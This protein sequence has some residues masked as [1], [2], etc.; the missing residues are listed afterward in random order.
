MKKINKLLFFIMI[1]LSCILLSGCS[2]DRQPIEWD[3]FKF[4]SFQAEYLSL[5]Q[6][7]SLMV[8]CYAYGGVGSYHSGD[9]FLIKRDFESLKEKTNGR[10][11]FETDRY[12]V[13]ERCGEYYNIEKWSVW[14][15]GY[16]CCRLQCDWSYYVIIDETKTDYEHYK[17]YGSIPFPAC[18]LDE[19]NH[20]DA[21]SNAYIVGR[22]VI[23][24]KYRDFLIDYYKN[25]YYPGCIKTYKKIILPV[26]DKTFI[27]H[28]DDTITITME[29]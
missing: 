1:F 24:E 3:T 8:N 5:T 14:K 6:E 13:F 25:L 9:F 21:K 15:E 11:V 17:Q 2:Y 26:K 10:F 22:T 23:D 4:V 27:V 29:D 7:S 19:W 18:I 16:I 28:F 20:N 12:L